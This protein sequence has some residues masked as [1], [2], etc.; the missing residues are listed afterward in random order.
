MHPTYMRM[1]R[2]MEESEKRKHRKIERPWMLYILRCCNNTFYTGVTND[3]ERR[4]KLHNNGQAS[5][6]TRSRRPV[7]LVYSEVCGGRAK[8]LVRECRVKALSRP[9][10]ERLIIDGKRPVKRKGKR[11]G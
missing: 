6:Y 7:E 9:E 8:A 2:K 10:K 5:R 11:N 4:L 3:I 1:I